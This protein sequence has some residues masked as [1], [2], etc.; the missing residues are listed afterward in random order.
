MNR[1]RHRERTYVSCICVEGVFFSWR[2]TSLNPY[3]EGC[4]PMEALDD[5]GVYR[6]TER[7]WVTSPDDSG[8]LRSKDSIE[9]IWKQFTR[10]TQHGVPPFGLVRHRGFRT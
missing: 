3:F 1:H 2:A 8:D 6:H 9:F 5:D 4:S 10:Q 7:R